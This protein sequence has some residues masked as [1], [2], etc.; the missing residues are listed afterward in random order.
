MFVSRWSAL[1]LRCVYCRQPTHI[2]A[3]RFMIWLILTEIGRFHLNCCN[4][5]VA[6]S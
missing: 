1:S 6:N 5:I 2:Q 3:I 4:I